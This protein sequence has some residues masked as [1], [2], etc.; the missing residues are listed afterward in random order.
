MSKEVIFTGIKQFREAAGMTK[1]DLARRMGVTHQAVIRW[2]QGGSY[3][4]AAKLLQLADL[5]HCSV[6]ELLGRDRSA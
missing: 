2:E 3:P 6:D 4:T 1:T 5:F